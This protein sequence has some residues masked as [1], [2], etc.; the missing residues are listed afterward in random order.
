MKFYFTAQF[1]RITIK[2]ERP[3]SEISLENGKIRKTSFYFFKKRNAVL[4]IYTV[5]ARARSFENRAKFLVE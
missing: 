5:H 1:L 2:A 3:E 4:F